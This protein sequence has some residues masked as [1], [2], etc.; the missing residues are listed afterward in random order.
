[1][2]QVQAHV[3]HVFQASTHYSVTLNA[4]IAHMVTA[5]LHYINHNKNVVWELG[6]LLKPLNVSHVMMVMYAK[7]V[8][9]IMHQLTLY[10]QLVT[11]V[12]TQLEQTIHII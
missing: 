4:R 9:D 11:I 2:L 10:V 8:Q 7:V 5:V 1:V 3:L 12:C 6:Q